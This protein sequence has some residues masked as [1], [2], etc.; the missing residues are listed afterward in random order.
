VRNFRLHC[1]A[2]KEELALLH[3]RS[4]ARGARIFVE[5]RDDYRATIISE[6]Y[7]PDDNDLRQLAE[8]GVDFCGD[9]SND[10][11]GYVTFAAHSREFVSCLAD[12]EYYPVACVDK[13]GAREDHVKAAMRYW[14]LYSILFDKWRF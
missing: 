4:V 8:M 12:F 10:N 13:T 6:D 1:D 3:L 14:Q 5:E 11:Y 9:G 7:E 2:S